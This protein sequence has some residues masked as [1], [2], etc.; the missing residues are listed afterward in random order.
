MFASNT[1][2]F[3]LFTCNGVFSQCGI[4]TFINVKDVAVTSSTSA[5]HIAQFG[6]LSLHMLTTRYSIVSHSILSVT[7]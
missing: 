1:F 6:W 4:A 5:E 2:A 7:N 3:Y